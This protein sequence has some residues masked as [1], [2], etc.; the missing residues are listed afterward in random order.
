MINP[1]FYN[2]LILNIY[3][4]SKLNLLALLKR[5]L[6]CS[7]YVA[8]INLNDDSNIIINFE[9][10]FTHLLIGFDKGDYFSEPDYTNRNIAIKAH[11]DLLA[12]YSHD[13]IL[14]S[15]FKA[16]EVDFK[17]NQ[18]RLVTKHKEYKSTDKGRPPADKNYNYYVLLNFE[19]KII[20]SNQIADDSI[21]RDR[22][23][24]QFLNHETLFVF[25]SE[26]DEFSFWDLRSKQC[27]S[28]R[29][30]DYESDDDD[31]N[32]K[33]DYVG[34]YA[35]HRESKLIIYELEDPNYGQDCIK[36]A[37]ID[38]SNLLHTILSYTFEEPRLCNMAFNPK[39][40]EFSIIEI[41]PDLY[42]SNLPSVNIRTFLFEPDLLL[43]HTISTKIN[44]SSNHIKEIYYYSADIVCINTNE[45]FFLYN[46]ITGAEVGVIDREPKSPYYVS[47]NKI[48][49]VKNKKLI[50]FSVDE[51]ELP[52]YPIE[53]EK[54]DVKTHF[55][56]KTEPYQPKIK[57]PLPVPANYNEY[58][59]AKPKTSGYVKFF[60]FILIVILSWAK[61][62]K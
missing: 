27:T 24:L 54:D 59:S 7:V 26:Q 48:F 58:Q 17:R 20:L 34:S 1:E 14:I 40:N 3:H 60:L 8:I 53:E 32:N 52:A 19:G 28:I 30:I 55:S 6:D 29:V 38:D 45:T 46:I 62:N 23:S 43:K 47:I 41:I 16:F 25:N 2:N 36:V 51:G 42:G 12:D 39:G 21:F 37:R 61:C 35:L 11:N 33:Y 15:V 56:S 44:H 13:F 57:E 18:I 5:R 4:D 22:D 50:Y 31:Y 49:Y 10:I 9:R